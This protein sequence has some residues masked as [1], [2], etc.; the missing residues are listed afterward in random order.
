MSEMKINIDSNKR[1]IEFTRPSLSQANE[2]ESML[3]S[4]KKFDL[5]DRSI[6]A[7]N[8]GDMIS[9]EIRKDDS[10]SMHK[11]FQQA[12]GNSAESM[13]KKRK[14]LITLPKETAEP[15]KLRSKARDYLEILTTISEIKCEYSEEQLTSLRQKFILRL[16]E[17]SSFDD[18]RKIKDRMYENSMGHL[19]DALNKIADK[20]LANL[21]LDYQYAWYLNS[22]PAAVPSFEN[23]LHNTTAPSI[24]IADVMKKID[25]DS[26]AFITIP[27]EEYESLGQGDDIAE[28]IR[29]NLF[30]KHSEIKIDLEE[31][32]PIFL[33]DFPDDCHDLET[34]FPGLE[35]KKDISLNYL[36][37]SSVYLELRFDQWTDK[38]HI[39]P[40]WKAIHDL[41]NVATPF[42]ES[43]YDDLYGDD[44][45]AS[46]FERYSV[47]DPQQLLMI[48]YGYDTDIFS[49]AEHGIDDEGNHIYA[50]FF[51]SN[52]NGFLGQSENNF[53]GMRFHIPWH[54]YGLEISFQDT[55]DFL[56]ASPSYD[57]EYNYQI[58][59][60]IEEVNKFYKDTKFSPAPFQSF[61]DNIL[62]NLAY[63]SEGNRIDTLLLKDAKEKFKAFKDYE[64]NCNKNYF[65]SVAYFNKQLKPEG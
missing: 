16:V 61:A 2:I 34:A 22:F 63:A 25:V 12:F 48:F 62:T 58:I 44:Y 52:Q 8:L 18:Q 47:G 24:K 23:L 50:L 21:D 33:D 57:N 31:E 29:K 26:C 39:I 54:S 56:M 5:R 27:K 15:K 14:S 38:W 49:A 13:Y 46:Y 19:K 59:H 40:S 1:K 3:K 17:G 36:K 4:C 9:S 7:R 6:F 30:Q 55:L 45:W 64:K 53:R 42:L 35:F 10:L 28:L 37:K 11:I 43:E 51:T 60:K 41:D 32:Y 65:D 20:V